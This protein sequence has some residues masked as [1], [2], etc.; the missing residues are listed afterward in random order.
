MCGLDVLDFCFGGRVIN[1]EILAN[2]G[3]ESRFV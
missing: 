3:D 1:A 2:S